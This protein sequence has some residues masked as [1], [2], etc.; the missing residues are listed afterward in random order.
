MTEDAR[1]FEED[2]AGDIDECGQVSGLARGTEP[3]AAGALKS[4]VIGDP[5]AALD[6]VLGRVAESVLICG[7]ILLGFF[8][9]QKED[10]IVRILSAL[11]QKI[12]LNSPVKYKWSD[13]C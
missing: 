1:A 8:R 12:E 11:D 2:V 4:R 6:A 7:E 5:Y 3:P 10:L 9:T 13:S